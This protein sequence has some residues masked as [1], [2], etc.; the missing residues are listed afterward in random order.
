M[1]R[2]R[3]RRSARTGFTLVELL[4]V[5]L[6]LAI[7]IALLVPAIS[8]AVKSA[9]DA[10]VNAEIANLKTALASFKSAFNEYPPSRII[11]DEAN[12]YAAAS[13]RP[14]DTARVDVAG[15]ADTSNTATD[16]TYGELRQ[17]SVRFL[18]KMFPRAQFGAGGT[19]IDF[20]LNGNATEEL[21]LDGNQCLVFFL[22]GMF[23]RTA[24]PSGA[25]VYSV[26]GFSKD[27]RNPF[28]AATNRTQPMYEFTSSR[29]T[30]LGPTVSPSNY[31]S[32]MPSYLDPLSGS[33]LED[34]RP[35][36]Y[37]SANGNGQYDPNDMNWKE[38]DENGALIRR[39]F[40][41]SGRRVWS[42]S[43]NPYSTNAPTSGQN[44]PGTY[45]AQFHNPQTYQLISAGRDRLWGI[46]G[47]WSQ[48]GE[49]LANDNFSN[50]LRQGEA[51]N[52]SD[53]AGGKL[54]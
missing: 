9:K 40:D 25:P 27:P 30:V 3:T 18:R 8:G 37:F 20:N 32:G 23:T 43:P 1:P 45:N 24:D 47:S 22:G 26:A 28:N 54:D 44:A 13:G 6:I 31:S 50:G 10:Q 4:V 2:P 21:I 39:P 14:A 5:I 36:A 34:M 29:L 33:S 35:Y 49:R 42:A 17:R 15:S 38:Q 53:F 48:N 52:L 16:L 41:Y 11:L 12:L 51:D 19:G 46:G 7:L